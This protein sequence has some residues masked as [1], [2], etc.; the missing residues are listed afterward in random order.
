MKSVDAG[1]ENEVLDYQHNLDWTEVKEELFKLLL[2]SAAQ[3]EGGSEDKYTSRKIRQ[4]FKSLIANNPVQEHVHIVNFRLPT[5]SNR[6]TG[7]LWE[8]VDNKLVHMETD[9]WL[10]HLKQIFKELAKED[11]GLGVILYR[12]KLAEILAVHRPEYE[13]HYYLLS[14]F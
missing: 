5:G 12:L 13:E 9:L 2:V 6:S 8:G 11:N 7:R 4:D 10:V 3:N 1:G 14:S